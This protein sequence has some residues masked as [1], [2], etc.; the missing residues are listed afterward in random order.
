MPAQDIVIVGAGGFG[1]EVLQWITD[2]NAAAARWNVIGFVDGNAALHGTAIHDVPVLGDLEWLAGRSGVAAAIS[3]GSPSVKR[4]LAQQVRAVG[5]THPTLVHPLAIV[6]RGVRLGLGA[7]VCPTAILTTDLELGE[8]VTVN[9]GLSVG[10]DAVIGDYVT[11]AP[12]V[13]ISGYVRLGEGCD[14][15]TNAMFTPGVQVGAWSVV[16]AGAVV[17]A[18]LPSNVTAVGVPAKVIKT[19][20]D[21]WHR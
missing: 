14:V 2:I 17:S 10:H 8:L 19:R 1:R 11:L 13:R 15:G 18:D 16:G 5:A 20:P 3:I 6:G 12:G 21:G 7:I 4:K 9:V